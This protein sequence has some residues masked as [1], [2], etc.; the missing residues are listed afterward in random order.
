MLIKST[1]VHIHVLHNVII[2]IITIYKIIPELIVCSPLKVKLE[3]NVHQPL[4]NQILASQLVGIVAI[5][6]ID[7]VCMNFIINK[8][9]SI[10]S[11]QG[12]YESNYS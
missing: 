4:T 11:E 10:V 5:L 7:C 3:G 9:D 2:L 1:D 12:C 8:I 6:L